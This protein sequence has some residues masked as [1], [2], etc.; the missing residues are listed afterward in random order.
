MTV[1]ETIAANE[2]LADQRAT[3]EFRQ[4]VI[5]DLKFAR[6]SCS[7]LLKGTSDAE[8]DLPPVSDHTERG[9]LIAIRVLLN[10]ALKALEAI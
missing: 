4:D 2:M 1:E 10:D 9:R 3:E 7:N 6:E 5:W 8:G